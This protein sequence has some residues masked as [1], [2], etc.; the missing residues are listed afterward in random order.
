MT[1]AWTPD[2]E[3]GNNLIDSEHK[4]LFRA[5]NDLL[6][7]C[8]SGQG[9]TALEKT[10]DF[11]SSYTV[12]HFGD[13]ENL[14]VKYG[15]PDYPNHKQLHTAFVKFVHDLC[16]KIK[17]QGPTTVL[18]GQVTTGVGDWLINH[19]KR[20]DVKVSAHLRTAGCT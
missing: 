8:K 18:L 6:T 12:K 15:Y 7:A 16:A 13:E 1:Y 2:L 10:L 4:E 9:K 11:L 5:I 20:E 14:Q 17:A 3:T 19:I